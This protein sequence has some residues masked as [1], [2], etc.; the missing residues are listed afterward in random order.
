MSQTGYAL[1]VNCGITF[2]GIKPASLFWLDDEASCDL[3]Y[4]RRMFSKKHF[5]FMAVRQAQ[6]RKLFYVFNRARLE[7][8]LFDEENHNFLRSLGY[9]YQTIGGALKELKTRMEA[10]EDFPHEVG[11]FLGYPLEDVLGFIEDRRGGACIECGYWKV[12]GQEEKKAELFR[13]YRKCSQCIC[14]KLK[15][16]TPLERIFNVG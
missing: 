2:A 4:Y 5:Y 13:R 6:G 15:D 3:S 10:N 7:E 1:G 14:E 9:E 11:L 8:I 12:Y 16:G